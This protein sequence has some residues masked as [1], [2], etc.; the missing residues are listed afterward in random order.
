MK[1]EL[2]YIARQQFSDDEGEAD[3]P[4]APIQPEDLVEDWKSSRVTTI[5]T[6]QLGLMPPR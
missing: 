5:K 6:K 3:L 2:G 4:L 1:S